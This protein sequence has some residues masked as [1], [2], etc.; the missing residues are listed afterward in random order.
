MKKP[1]KHKEWPQG[2][3]KGSGVNK[4]VKREVVASKPVKTRYS[5]PTQKQ[6]V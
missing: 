2:S 4:P 5:D 6:K 1:A 3:I